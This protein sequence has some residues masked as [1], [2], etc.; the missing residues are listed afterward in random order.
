MAFSWRNLTHFSE[1]SLDGL[2]ETTKIL[3]KG[4]WSP[5]HTVFGTGAF[6]TRIKY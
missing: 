4:N 5:G 6:R 3:G 1:I 2:R